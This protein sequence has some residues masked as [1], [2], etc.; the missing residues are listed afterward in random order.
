MAAVGPRSLPPRD[1]RQFDRAL[2][3]LDEALRL[4]PPEAKGRVLVKKAFTLEQAGEAD[5]AIEALRQAALRVEA[6]R[7]PRL[8]LCLLFNLAVNLCHLHQPE[9]ADELFPEIQAL[10]E[11]VDKAL[12]RLR[13]AWL[14]A[15]IDAGRGRREEARVGLGAVR[16]AFLDRRM[17]YEVA[18]VSLE[19]AVLLLEDG[20]TAEVRELAGPMLEI[21]TAQRIGR[22]ALATVEVFARAARQEAV[23]VEWTR[24]LLGKLRRA[25]SS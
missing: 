8:R 18:L 7:E 1:Q 10:A 5:R 17:S 9:E 13:T 21:F 20:R 11:Q 25:G 22:E 15:K 12:D 23:T 2:A 14:R 24:D 3:L 4:C 6:S 19:L 16:Q